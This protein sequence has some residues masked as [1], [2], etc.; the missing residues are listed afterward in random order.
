[1]STSLS[2]IYGCP[3]KHDYISLKNSNEYK[4][5]ISQKQFCENL[6]WDVYI[7]ARLDPHALVGAI[8]PL[9]APLPGCPGQLGNDPCHPPRTTV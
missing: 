3:I 4:N 9:V 6:L 2:M 7:S 1:M 8:C 5:S